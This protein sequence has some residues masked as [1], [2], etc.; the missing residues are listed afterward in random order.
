MGLSEWTAKLEEFDTSYFLLVVLGLVGL[1]AAILFRVGFIS[2]L[3][4]AASTLIRRTI[5]NG[6]L[7]WER[8][9]SWAPWTAVLGMSA[10]LWFGGLILGRWIPVVR[11]LCGLAL[12]FIGVV[13]CFA[14]MYVDSERSE[15]KRGHKA[16]FKPL[17][18]QAIARHLALYGDLLHVPYL[19]TAS[20]ATVGGFALL[21]QGVFESG[22]SSWYEI[23]EKSDGPIYVDFLVYAIVKLLGLLDVLDVA[24]SHHL[25]GE[26]DVRPVK[27]PATA[28]LVAFKTFFTVVLVQQISSS[29]RQRRNLGETINDFWSPHEPIHDR[30]RDALPQYG[31]M[32]IR[33]LLSS[34]RA[35]SS[36]TKELRDELP[37][38]LATVGPSV[39]PTLLRHLNDPHEHVRAIAVAA[40]GLLRVQDATPLLVAM[41]K[42]PSDMIRQ[43][44]AEALGSI[45]AAAVEFPNETRGLPLGRR[46]RIQLA[47]AWLRK[48]KRVHP[49]LRKAVKWLQKQEKFRH[50]RF[51][52]PVQASVATL[53]KALADSIPAVRAAA[54]VAVGVIGP[55]AA[56]VAP[57]LIGLLNEADDLVRCRAAE[58][59]GKLGGDPDVVVEAVTRLLEDASP[60]VKTTAIQTLGEMGEAAAPAVPTIVR[61]LQDRDEAVREAA[62]ATL[63]RLGPLDEEAIESLVEGLESEDTVVRARTAEAL[64]AIGAPVGEAAPALVE[65]IDDDNDRV[66]AKAVQALGMIGE[67]A[68]PAAVPGL[69]RALRD[70]DNWVSALAAEAL[71]Q[72]GESSEHTIEALVQSLGHVNSWVRANSAEALGRMG[73]AA[74]MARIAL[75]RRSS[76]E[77]AGVR[78]QVIRALGLI[79]P[80]DNSSLRIVLEALDDSD[81]FV[82]VAA[83]ETLGNWEKSSDAIV[84]ALLTK[85]DDPNEEVKARV[86]E[87]LPHLA[88]ATDDVIEALCRRLREDVSTWV[89]VHAARALGRL[90]TEA[91]AAGPVLLEAARTGDVTV[92]EQAMRALVLIQP[93]EATPAFVSGLKDPSGDVRKI[94]SAGWMKAEVIPEE[95]IPTLIDALRDPEVQVRANASH[96][97]ARVETLPASAVPLL[98]ECASDPSDGLRMNSALALVEET[99]KPV[100]DLMR[101]LLADPN[102]RVSLIAAEALLASEPENA[103][104][105]AVLTRALEDPDAR[106]RKTAQGVIAQIEEEQVATS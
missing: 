102:S 54:A 47:V 20:A 44:V 11:V 30:A 15:V 65:A 73:E 100:T 10:G 75:E 35:F 77:D 51:V 31:V 46:S 49:R 97:L 9:L 55:A 45:G 71:G 106:V 70:R 37:V 4:Q 41:A 94:A 56:R 105:R 72:M 39:T 50:V 24:R 101:R 67:A 85:L 59:L 26:L 22:G 57:S 87:V 79:G 43:N 36:L 89:Q 7:L 63:A 42:D 93:E 13:A 38:V 103:E 40:L 1:I 34:L 96:A 99:G 68:A 23:A 19:I 84:S 104:A 88:G 90:G 21:N 29:L 16:V 64:G 3:L 48:R 33:P 66:R 58:A 78:S 80:A 52:D 18:G 95:A 81:S 8:S 83:V 5:R 92:R 86:A 74:K 76:D 62:A 91:T 98:I 14:Y 25:V 60:I 53:E 28:M 69:L 2:W 17:K 12:L 82:R 27:W 61:L 32:A 6:F